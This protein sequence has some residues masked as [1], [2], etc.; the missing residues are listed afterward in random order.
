M[1][2]EL[3]Y[4]LGMI[5]GNGKI[6]RNRRSTIV[7]IEIPHKKLITDDCKDIKVYVKASIADIRMMLEPLMG[8]DISFIQNQRSTVLSFEK[9]N[10][11]YLIRE[12]MRSYWKSIFS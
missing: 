3:A 12:V 10:E 1:N 7:S 6:Q 4:L 8:V 2:N 9:K 11:D 5:T